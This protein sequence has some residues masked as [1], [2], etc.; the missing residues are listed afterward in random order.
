MEWVILVVL[1]IVV[2]GIAVGIALV[3][4]RRM[5]A[6]GMVAALE[7]F[8]K[9]HVL[10]RDALLFGQES[11]GVTQLRGNGTLLLTD[12]ELYF[13]RWVPMT[14]YTIPLRSI[15]AL[16]TPKVHLG[17]SYGKPL[18]KV[19]YQRDDGQRDSIAWYVR[20]LESA[21]AQIEAMRAR[22]TG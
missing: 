7:K 12:H 15:S 21:I 13:R 20:D 19:N 11:K 1:V 22:A 10:G 4:V 8:P 14:E 16:E 17:K 6:S 9:A 3:V 18:L 2:V 5:A